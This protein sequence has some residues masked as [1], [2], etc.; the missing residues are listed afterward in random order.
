MAKK[1]G[2]ATATQKA[3][4]LNSLLLMLRKGQSISLG[5]LAEELQCS[6]STVL[7]LIDQLEVCNFAKIIKTV[8]NRENRYAYARPK[9]LPKVCITAQGLQYLLLCRDLAADVLPQSMRSMTSATLGQA[10]AFLPEDEEVNFATLSET[11]SKGQIDY[12]PFATQMETIMQCIRDKRVCQIEYQAPHRAEPRLF[13][14]APLRL[15]VYRGALYVRA[16][17]VTEKGNAEAL[18]DTPTVFALHRIREAWATCRTTDHLPDVAETNNGFGFIKDEPFSVQI[19]FSPAVSTYI[20]ER[21]W[22]AD[23]QIDT[24]EDGSVTL[25]MSST[26]DRE[27]IAWVL[28][29]GKEAN[30]LAPAHLKAQIARELSAMQAQYAA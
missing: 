16:W 25:T 14:I 4:N 10:Q 7:R 8:E 27:V 17:K 2:S 18:F 12:S 5:K 29:F 21:K 22:S 11:C 23:Q 26:S 3:L 6:R 30:L 28:G 13:E 1:L 24:H 15:R 9:A 19:R 20:A